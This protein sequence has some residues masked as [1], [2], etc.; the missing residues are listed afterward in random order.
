MYEK[1]ILSALFV[2]LFF[3][4]L[5]LQ[6]DVRVKSCQFPENQPRIPRKP[7]ATGGVSF[8]GTGVAPR[9]KFAAAHL[10][11]DQAMDTLEKN[12]LSTT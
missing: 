9:R 8:I 2:N 12:G 1:Y 6:R 5:S 4:G 11:I 3:G 7:S 10:N